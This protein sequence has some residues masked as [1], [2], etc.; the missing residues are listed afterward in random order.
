MVIGLLVD[1]N[2]VTWH[3]FLKASCFKKHHAY[4]Q[5]DL[6]F[7]VAACIASPAA[8]QLWA[9]QI[10]QQ[11]QKLRLPKLLL[12]LLLLL[13]ASCKICHPALD[14]LYLLASPASSLLLL[15]R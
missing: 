10:R 4:Q 13:W 5:Q 7:M 2:Q 12:L 3:H 9:A 6:I 1:R 15:G 14:C 8:Q 11:H